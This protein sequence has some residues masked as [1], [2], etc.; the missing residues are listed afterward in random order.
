VFISWVNPVKSWLMI[1]KRTNSRKINEDGKDM[2]VGKN[3]SLFPT[4]LKLFDQIL[5][6]I[7]DTI[8]PFSTALNILIEIFSSIWVWNQIDL[9]S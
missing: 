1:W 5:V 7:T 3:T 6:N 2:I 8:F 4:F 9:G